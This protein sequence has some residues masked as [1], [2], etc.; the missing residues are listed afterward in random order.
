MKTKN[1]NQK[2]IDFDLHLK[3]RCHQCSQDHWLS[4]LEAS[5]QNFKIVCGCGEVFK[6]KRIKS[7]KINYH[8]KKKTETTPQKEESSSHTIP[9]DI[10]N[11]C[12]KILVTYGF[13]ISEASELLY[14]TYSKN[15]VDD[16]GT[17]IKNTLASLKG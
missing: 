6:V 7:F 12:V 1:K 2:P 9:S 17:L 4:Y 13:T 15:P 8:S 3:Y 11:K 14:N 10:L 16:C 5:T